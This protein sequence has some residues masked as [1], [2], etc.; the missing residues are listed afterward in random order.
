MVVF[1]KDR[2][3]RGLFDMDTVERI[4]LWEENMIFNCSDQEKENR[5]KGRALKFRSRASARRVFDCMM[6]RFKKG[7]KVFALEREDK[8]EDFSLNKEPVYVF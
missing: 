6:D 2:A 5:K 1:V 8:D 4:E 7:E 3:D